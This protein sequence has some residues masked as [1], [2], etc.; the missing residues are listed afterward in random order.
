MQQEKAIF[1]AG[2]FW[3]VQDYFSQISGVTK[4]TVGYS[5]GFIEDPTYEEVCT[6]QTGHAEAILIEFDPNLVSYETLLKHF[7][8]LH[9]PTQYMRQ[10]PDVGTQYR[11]AVF[12]FSDEQRKAA[13]SYIKKIKPQFNEEIVTEVT[14]ATEF[15]SAEEY[16]QKFTERTGKGAC[17]VAYK[18]ID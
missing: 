1:A 3:G 13:E 8:I 15:Y 18:P 12:F 11:S 2:C 14:A 10:G 16:H 7:F 6:G 4:T 17:H 9:D 5:G